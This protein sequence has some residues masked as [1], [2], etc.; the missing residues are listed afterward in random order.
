MAYSGRVNDVSDIV[1]LLQSK[2]QQVRQL[3]PEHWLWN[4]C[5]LSA[6]NMLQ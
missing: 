6:R 2:V 4:Y 3:S 5:A 1:Y